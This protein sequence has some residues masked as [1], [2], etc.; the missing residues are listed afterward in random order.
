MAVKITMKFSELKEKLLA[1][2]WVC[3]IKNQETF[4]D[5]RDTMSNCEQ[6]P[7][8]VGLNIFINLKSGKVLKILSDKETKE[9]KNIW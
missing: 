1:N 7:T 2:D 9:I 8:G 3:V 6:V 5:K 4:E